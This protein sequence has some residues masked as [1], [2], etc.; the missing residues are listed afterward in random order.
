MLPLHS[1]LP[2]KYYLIILMLLHLIQHINVTNTSHL[3]S[4]NHFIF[5]L[6]F[7]NNTYQLWLFHNL[8]TKWYLAKSSNS[9]PISTAHI[10]RHNLMCIAHFHFLFRGFPVWN[11]LSF[12]KNSKSF[13]SRIQVR[14]KSTILLPVS[15]RTGVVMDSTNLSPKILPFRNKPYCSFLL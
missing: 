15:L 13:I 1:H 5:T 14:F 9:I 10:L 3:T 7:K 2:S 8:W 4:V 11:S 12:S 6:D